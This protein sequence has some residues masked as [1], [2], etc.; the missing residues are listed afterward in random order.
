MLST[1]YLPRSI[2]SQIKKNI[3]VGGEILSKFVDL[4]GNQIVIGQAPFT[5]T[6]V[7]FRITSQLF[8]PDMSLKV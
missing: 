7:N 8:S 3:T 4:I 2:K 5:Y 1:N 6:Q